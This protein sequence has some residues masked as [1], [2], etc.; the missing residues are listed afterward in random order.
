MYRFIIF[1]SLLSTSLLFSQAQ[2]KIMSYNLLNYPGND[3]AIRNPYFSTVIQN[4]NPDILVVQE[5]LSQ[6]GMDGFLNNVLNLASS[7]YAAGTFLDGPDTDNGIFYKTDSFTFVANNII[8]TDL[9]NISEFILKE[10]TT[11]DTIRIYSLHL[12]A[13]NTFSD[14]QQRLVEVNALRSVTDNLPPNSNYI[15]CGDFNIYGSTDTSYQRLLDQSSSGYFIDIYNLTGAWNNQN[16]AIYHT[17][18]P[19]VRS[20][21]GGST[22][23]MDDR[24]DMILFSPAII[25]TGDIYYIPNSFVNYGNDGNHYNDSINKPPNAVVSQQVA[26][27]IHYSSDHIPVFAT[28]SFEQNNTQISINVNDGWNIVSVPLLAPDMSAS[29]LFPTAVSPFYSFTT[30]YVQVSTLENGKGYWV[31]FNGNQ[32]VTISGQL[33]STNSINVNQG[34]SIIGP[35][36]FQVPVPTITTKPPNI[37]ASTF[38]GFLNIYIQAN[39][40]QPGQGY[41]VKTNSSGTINLNLLR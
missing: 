31:K 7:G 12:K 30:S 36:N 27:A 37:I 19:R 23:G 18:S 4:T 25:S 33:I 20:F 5:M 9:R 29:V 26:D 3:S 22:G 6:S 40:L 15:V 11:S 1:L 16:Y 13:G 21:G 14:E 28:F 32:S 2:H 8:I 41:W 10:N 39:T 35:F 34:W 17:Q 38:Y 24:F